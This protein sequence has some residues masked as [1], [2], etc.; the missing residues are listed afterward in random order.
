MLDE[1]E[2]EERSVSV[3]L[4]EKQNNNLYLQCII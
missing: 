4:I 3:V 2:V 1:G